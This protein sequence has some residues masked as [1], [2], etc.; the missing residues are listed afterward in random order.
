MATTIIG[1][2]KAYIRLGVKI[3]ASGSKIQSLGCRA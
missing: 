2:Y 3:Q 1:L